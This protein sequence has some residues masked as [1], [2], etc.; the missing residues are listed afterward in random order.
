LNLVDNGLKYTLAG[1]R[2]TLTLQQDGAWAVLRVADTGI[3]LAPEEQ[4]RVFQR[5]YRAPTAVSRDVE[6]SGLGLCIARSI[7]EAHGGTIQVE[8]A[9]GHGSLFTVRLPL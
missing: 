2:V 6:G 4:E 1:G 3:G 7:V 5:F 9:V 8:S